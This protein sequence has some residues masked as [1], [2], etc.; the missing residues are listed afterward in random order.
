[1]KS[2]ESSEIPRQGYFY[3]ILAAVLWA[4]SGSLSKFLF[5]RGISPFEL[6]Q[7]R[8]TISAVILFLGLLI[9]R[10]FLLKI[11]RKDIF[12]F[13]MLGTAGMAA[14][15][16]T[17]LFAISKI[18]VAAA[19]LLQYLAPGFIV[20]HSVVIV[21]EKPSRAAILSMVGAT[22]GCYLV[23][24]AY[25][26]NVLTM[27]YAGIISGIISAIAFA[28]YSIYS[29]YGMRR[30]HP[31]TVLSFGMLIAAVV[32]N[33]LQP[34]LK[35]FFNVY[36]PMEWICII[37]IGI[38]GTIV[39]F[40][41]YYEAINRIRATRAGITAT[42][43]PIIAGVIS[44]LFLNEV[45]EPLQVTGGA[46]VIASVAL[47]QLRREQDNHTPVIIRGQKQDRP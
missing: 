36:S 7:L 13:I 35:A 17:Y 37:Y 9:R 26:L 25:N 43:E 40:G 39:P 33:I 10:P 45:M 31:W 16:F 4:S 21:R 32:W 27:N 6:V 30:Y 24:G 1:M 46:M 28:G 47:L 11:S 44:Y 22:I 5:N 8:I 18:N 2:V 19:I 42:L 38:L 41:L 29:E 12:Y 3:V 23:V 20:L 14:V 34:P 15:Q